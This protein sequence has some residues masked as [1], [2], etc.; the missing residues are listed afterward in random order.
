[1]GVLDTLPG[2][3]ESWEREENRYG[4]FQA[5]FRIAGDIP[6]RQL[7]QYWRDW[8]GH[9][10]S[11]IQGRVVLWEG[12]VHEMRLY[13]GD[14]CRVRGYDV[15]GRSGRYPAGMYNAVRVGLNSLIENPEFEIAGANPPLFAS[16]T[17]SIAG[18]DTLTAET[19]DP[20]KGAQSPKL[21]NVSSGN[22]FIYQDIPVTPNTTYS[23]KFVSCG[24]GSVAGRWRLR[25]ITGAADIVPIT[26]TENTGLGQFLTVEEEIVTP[27]NCVTMRLFFYA[28]ATAGWAVFDSVRV[29]RV[30][31]GEDG[32]AY[33]AWRVNAPSVGR[34]G[35]REIT[36]DGGGMTPAESLALRNSFLR[37]RAW[38]QSTHDNG[39]G[40]TRL[41]VTCLGYIHRAGWVHTGD[42]LNGQTAVASNHVEQIAEALDW[43]NSVAIRANSLSYTM[44]EEERTL[45]QA[46]IDLSNL[47][48]AS[49]NL[50]R[51]HAE[52]GRRLVYGPVNFEPVLS[53]TNGQLYR[54]LGDKE[55]ADARQLRAMSVIRD[56]DFPDRSR[57]PSSQLE[58]RND[59]LME[60]ITVGPSG[61]RRS[62]GGL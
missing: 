19:T 44:P 37:E 49:E 13:H 40:S 61:M 11:E 46:L 35:R 15:G 26:S 60:S 54:R 8:L 50:W 34:H 41:E 52:A 48:D 59:Y 57:D 21:T 29:A 10:V 56:Y 30:V 7:I 31:D 51:V 18:S 53:M 20:V 12:Y 28:P 38:P 6:L 47:G 17:Q 45:L 16:W 14:V 58:Q 32:Q 42:D 36:L 3:R 62:I 1:V 2:V 55:T 4:F 25:D 24:D 5:S 27:K 39:D 22:S 43:V 23:I 9:E 33:T